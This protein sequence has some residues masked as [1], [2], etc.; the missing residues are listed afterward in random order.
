MRPR[1]AG[2]ERGCESIYVVDI[3]TPKWTRQMDEDKIISSMFGQQ[4]LL[5]SS[6][7][8]LALILGALAGYRLMVGAQDQPPPPPAIH[9]DR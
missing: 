5:I 8:T 3:E 4:K 7:M 6:L 1:L 9:Q 2:N